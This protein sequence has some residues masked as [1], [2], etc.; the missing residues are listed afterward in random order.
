MLEQLL[1]ATMH[2][3]LL[4]FS[5]VLVVGAVLVGASLTIGG[6]MT[7]SPPSADAVAVQDTITHAINTLQ[8]ATIVVAPGALPASASDAALAARAQAMQSI[9]GHYFTGEPLARFSESLKNAL[10]TQ[11]QVGLRDVDGGAQQVQFQTLAIQGDQAAGTARA[12]IWIRTEPMTGDG[13]AW[14]PEGWWDYSFHAVRVGPG[15]LVDELTFK[16]EKGYEP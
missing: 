9:L 5:S 14:A 13:N 1:R 11:M 7:S 4:I 2:P 10:Q 15:R 6:D 8:T 16:P 12:L 3:R